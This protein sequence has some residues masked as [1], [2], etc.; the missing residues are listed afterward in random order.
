MSDSFD[1]E[2]EVR[3][4]LQCA[5]DY[6]W[7]TVEELGIA[8]PE[9]EFDA[10]A[11]EVELERR[12]IYFLFPNLTEAERATMEVIAAFRSRLDAAINTPRQ[13]LMPD[14]VEELEQTI[15]R[16]ERAF[17][18]AKAEVLRLFP[19][20]SAVQ[21]DIIRSEYLRIQFRNPTT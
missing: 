20:L 7:F 11:F 9:E 12:R 16:R 5:E 14:E 19:K 15:R 21:K 6:L 10:S 13:A 4:L 3:R 18:A 2:E 8:V 17:V 1:Q